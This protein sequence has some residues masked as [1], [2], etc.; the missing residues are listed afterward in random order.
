MLYNYYKEQ[1]CLKE[2]YDTFIIYL[3]ELKT[4][5]NINI[6]LEFIKIKYLNDELVI[7]NIINKSV[8]WQYIN[9]PEQNLEIKIIDMMEQYS[10]TLKKEEMESFFILLEN[11]LKKK[12][13]FGKNEF[14]LEFV[15][16][17]WIK[18]LKFP[19]QIP[20][21]TV[22]NIIESFSFINNF[23]G[24]PLDVLQKILSLPED[25][26]NME[27]FYGKALL[28]KSIEVSKIISEGKNIKIISNFI[29]FLV[30]RRKEIKS[31]DI[32]GAEVLNNLFNEEISIN[33][34]LLNEKIWSEVIKYQWNNDNLN[35]NILD[36]KNLINKYLSSIN[37]DSYTIEEIKIIIKN[38]DF[39]KSFLTLISNKNYFS[40]N[41][42]INI[43]FLNNI[44]NNIKEYEKRI[45]LVN[46][47]F[48]I[49]CNNIKID[50]S[51]I[52]NKLD[53]LKDDQVFSEVKNSFKDNDFCFSNDLILFEKLSNSD[54]FIQM[55]FNAI[56]FYYNEI[57]K[58]ENSLENEK[59][60]SIEVIYKEIYSIVLNKW[61]NLFKLINDKNINL[62]NL[63]DTFSKFDDKKC[64]KE[65]KIL[66]ETVGKNSNRFYYY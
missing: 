29:S 58:E 25:L 22:N 7:E 21:I 2:F 23:N 53:K 3:K 8:E 35:N 66:N 31:E 12:F 37:N 45:D 56:D 64:E 28:K 50:S 27:E 9:D 55:W 46:N 40:Q 59:K 43:K 52:K 41:N 1:E 32:I 30:N 47:F 14:P 51:S 60:I 44:E 24:E 26:V 54:I 4:L 61:K 33:S 57:I 5:K 16:K 36:M 38:E 49:F 48:R 17:I 62:E 18:I 65:L 63:R 6:L 42:N 13:I 34:I 20:V 10:N 11:W 15:I 19:I 39:K